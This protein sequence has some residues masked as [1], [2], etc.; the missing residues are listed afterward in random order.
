MAASSRLFLEQQGLLNPDVYHFQSHDELHL[1]RSE[2]MKRNWT[3]VEKK[4]IFG[5]LLLAGLFI[6]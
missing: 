2:Q 4:V 3:A 1:L 5:G 6:V